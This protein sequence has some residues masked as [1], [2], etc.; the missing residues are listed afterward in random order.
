MGI[1]KQN[2][3]K[4]TQGT[5]AVVSFWLSTCYNL[6]S[7]EKGVLVEELSRSGWPVGNSLDY[8]LIQEDPDHYKCLQCHYNIVEP[9]TM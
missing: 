6:K 5:P 1:K 3:L 4:Q 8:V 7:P 2:E 9:Q